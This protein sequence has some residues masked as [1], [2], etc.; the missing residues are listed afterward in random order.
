MSP[1]DTLMA[2]IAARYPLADGIV[3]FDLVAADGAQLPAFTAGA[4]I[5]V[6]TPGGPVRPYSLWGPP[7]EG[8]YRIA[9]QLE[10]AGRGGSAAMHVQAQE[11]SL[12]CISRPRNHFPLMETAP[13][14]LLLAG[15]IGITPLLAMAHRLHE[16]GAGF[17]LHH[18]TRTGGR[19]A[20]AQALRDSAF[21]ERVLHHHDDQPDTALDIAQLLRDSPPGTHLYVCGPQGFMDAALSEARRQGWAEDRL[22]KEYFS[23]PVATAATAAA[24]DHPDR[25]FLVRLAR[26]Q[27]IIP[28]AAGQTLVDALAAHGVH[29]PVSCEQ[30]LC[31]TCETRVLE[32]EVDHRDFHL[33]PKEQA[34]NDRLLACCSRARS[35]TLVLDL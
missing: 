4:H 2:R 3:G 18:A 25:A 22:H 1:P 19:A 12:L 35:D 29:I 32:G 9:V 8:R 23:A 7:A 30:G 13:R 34:L 17:T 33:S 24:P 28:V 14:S 20:F 26:T 31:G 11:G 15:G 16:L 10:P 27:R 6:H 5:D 21:A